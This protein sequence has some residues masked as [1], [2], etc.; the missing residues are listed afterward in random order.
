MA[1]CSLEGGG[2][3]EGAGEGN[4]EE[5]RKSEGKLSMMCWNVCG[6]SRKDGGDMSMMRMVNDM[7]EEVLDYYKPDILALVETWL[8]GREEIVVDGYKWFGC[9]RHTLHRKAVRGSGGVGVLIREEVLK[10]YTVEVLDSDVEGIL[11]L[12]LS[13]ERD[14]E[15]LVL[16]VCYIPPE[17]SSREV[18]V[19]EI[20]QSLGEQVAKF[21]SHGPMILCGDFNARCGRLDVE[22][23]GMPSRKVIDEVKNSQGEEFVDFLRSVNMGV[24]NGRKGKDAFTCVSNRG[25]SVVDYCVVGAENFSLINNFRVI[26]MTECIEEMQCKGEVTRVPDHSLV[27]WEVLGSWVEEKVEVKVVEKGHVKATRKRVPENYLEK[28]VEK[29]K[30]LTRRVVEAGADQKV[31]DDVYEELV[32][33]MKQGL[34]EVSRRKKIGVGQPW[35]SRELVSLRKEFHRVEREWLNCDNQEMRRRK[36]T[37]YVK[38]RKTYKVA[39]SRAKRKFNE[40]KYEELNG[41]LRNPRR[42]WRELQKMGVMSRGEKRDNITKVYNEVGEVAEGEEAVGVWKRH[43]EHVLNEGQ[44]AKDDEDQRELVAEDACRLVNADI[45]REEVVQA[46]GRLKQKAAPGRDGLS[47]EMMCCD[48]LVDFWWS[49]FNWCWRNGMT[50]SEW[51]KNVIVP[52]PK[53]RRR[54]ICE[55]DEFRGITLVSVVYKVMCSIVQQRMTQM[56][57][58][59]QL[60]AEEQGGFRKGRGCR[61]QVLTL[62]LLGQIKALSKRGMFAAFIDFRKAY[63]RVDRG[64][65]WQ[66]LEGMGFSGRITGFIRA[67]YKDLSGEVKVGEVLSEPFGMTCGLRQGCVLSPML[68]S[69]YI[70]SLVEKLK[71]AGV[72][73]ECRGRLITA[74]LY[75]DDAV[76]VAEDEGQ[77]RVSL[78]V[79]SEWCKQ[80]S[81]EVNVE[82]CGVMH[83]RRRGVKRTGEKFYVDSKRIEVVEEYKYLGCVINE[84]L[85]TR[86]M[87][88]ERAKAG[89][90][91]L[92]EWLRKCRA[93]VGE[94]RGETFVK[95][96]EVLVG[97]VLMY[98]AEVWGGGCQTGPV[99]A[100][101][102]RAAR[103]FLG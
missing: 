61:D 8:K 93:V 14:E 1:S 97:S 69:L 15:S 47:A 80:W 18:G 21:R 67:I 102:M 23:E 81:V 85:G 87:V 90:R 94:L 103:I 54:G 2:V 28:E 58:E 92:S 100:V 32:E 13:K 20:L 29:V 19:E 40:R 3:V 74:L 96:M 46:L 82:K 75:A 17:S 76:L 78:G 99:E 5:G 62:M 95:L 101:Q 53:K 30:S 52:I 68:F 9:N 55:V 65:L 98:G 35:F 63:D 66:C 10:E 89:A 64:K 36:R 25:R 39:V 51:R 42:W 57:E 83:M 44:V 27:Q 41:L 79:L 12:R 7:R 38:I 24:V 48:V 50:P 71:A 73:V 34:V 86:R 49:L 26:T 72:G 56:V 16:A 70:N 4:D 11:W 6:W 84:Q 59:K 91:A 77:M 88:E 22:C 43:F 60:L 33:V 31:I 37:E 45:T